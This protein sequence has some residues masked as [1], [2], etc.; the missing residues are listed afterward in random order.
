MNIGIIGLGL[1]GGSFGRAI[2]NK[3]DN[4]VFAYDISQ[5]TMSSGKLL[6]AYHEVLTI[7]NANKL[8][9]LFISLYPSGIEKVLEEYCPYLKEGCIVADLCGNKREVVAA[10]KEKS[11]EYPTLQFIS[12]HPMAGREFSG[13][14]HSTLTMFDRASMIL[15]PVKAEINSIANLK[16]LSI[17]I[18]FLRV[19]I[20]T[21]ENHDK[22]IAF[23]SQLAHVVSSAYITNNSAEEHLGYSAGS[24]RDMTRVAKLNPYMWT[25]L[26][27]GN[28]DYLSKEID[29][30][31][32]NLQK[33]NNAIKNND[34]KALFDLLNKSN[35]RKIN[36]EK[37]SK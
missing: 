4:K 25:E 16:E 26:F 28:G 7:N 37:N 19:V 9:Y 34:E 23:T 27:L 22:M 13:I 15:V 24:F 21:A 29:E 12:C 14:R 3:T 11:I 32:G 17:K 20:T 31:I 8:D 6:T 30:F 35:E 5:T 36:I 2:I 1:I 10:L 18:G 33:I